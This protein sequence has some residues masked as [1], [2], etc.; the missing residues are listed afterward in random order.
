MGTKYGVEANGIRHHP[1]ASHSAI[2]LSAIE[3]TTAPPMDAPM[4]RR[5]VA[6]V[7]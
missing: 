4:T 5:T 7:K 3:A 2:I 6:R 1:R